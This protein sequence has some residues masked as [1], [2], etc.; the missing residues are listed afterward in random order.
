MLDA[1]CLY[2]AITFSVAYGFRMMYTNDMI[3]TLMC[4]TV[5]QD[6]LSYV[7]AQSDF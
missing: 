7:V 3:I 4:I 1:G 2:A 5:I 6:N